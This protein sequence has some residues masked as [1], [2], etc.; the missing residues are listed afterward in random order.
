MIGKIPLYTLTGLALALSVALIAP[1][2]AYGETTIWSPTPVLVAKQGDQLQYNV[3]LTYS[4]AGKG[5]RFT[6]YD[7]KVEELPQGWESSFRLAQTMVAKLTVVD[8][9]SVG[10][11]LLVT[12][13]PDVKPGEYKFRVIASA[14][15][16]GKTSAELGAVISSPVRKIVVASTYA[17]AEV[18]RGDRVRVPVRVANDGEV[19]ET[20]S[21]AVTKPEGWKVRVGP[22]G[23]NLTSIVLPAGKSEEYDLEV[24]P[25]GDAPRG[26]YAVTLSAS[27]RDGAQKSSVRVDVGYAAGVA[28][29]K[30]AVSARYPVLQGPSDTNFQ[31]RL[32]LSNEGVTDR[33]FNLA[34]AGPGGWAAGFKP[35]FEQ[36]YIST[37]SLKAGESRGLELDVNPPP[38]VPPGNY[39]LRVRAIAPDAEAGIQL[40]VQITGTFSVSIETASG[41][42][43]ADAVAGEES[44]AA[45]VVKNTGTAELKNVKL[46]ASRP[47]GWS[48]DLKP[49]QILELGP[50]EL[51]EVEM[52]MKPPSNAIAGD[53]LVTVTASSER[54]FKGADIRV[55]VSTSTIWGW[56]GVGI[57]AIALVGLYVLFMR[58][59]RR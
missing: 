4:S 34:V 53:Y 50:G 23:L 17:S 41:R 14:G 19:D 44:I 45:I 9:Q 3:T 13:P 31:F 54:A 46:S 55:G 11:K 30:T 15:E 29:G 40:S 18:P 12:P 7:L 1:P 47:S 6:S 28:V 58:L 21:F 43:N 56:V 33:T 49:E 37:I 20:I 10:V 25:G 38:K 57:I 35:E 36:R 32:D 39:T 42:L 24:I 59:G 22:F 27:T 16:A 48:I 26:K 2:Q 8:G 52:K 51:R 5:G